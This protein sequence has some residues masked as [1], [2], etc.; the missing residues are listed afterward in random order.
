MQI[1]V[2][3]FYAN[4]SP[5][6]TDNLIKLYPAERQ[7]HLMENKAHIILVDDEPDILQMFAEILRK[8]GFIVQEFL[9][10]LEALSFLRFTEKAVDLII[11]DLNMPVIDGL[12]F[13]DQVRKIDAF[14]ATPIIFLSAVMDLNYHLKAYKKGAI[15]FIQKPVSNEIFLLKINSILQSYLSNSLKD[16]I[17]DRGNFS[18]LNLEEIISFC[19]DERING[20]AYIA[21]K[22]NQAVIIFEKGVLKDINTSMLSGTAAFEE[23]KLWT[24]YQYLIVRGKYT[25]SLMNA[26]KS[27]LH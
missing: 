22:K 19:E 3:N 27:Q 2:Q 1:I 14:N 15:D 9:S 21:D 6:F 20:F 10:A 8:D 5:Q 24:K 12:K 16:N 11:T 23:V 13:V 4:V 25:A 7:K 18:K 26:V 17:V